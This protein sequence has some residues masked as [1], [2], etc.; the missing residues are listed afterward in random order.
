MV[1]I[2]SFGV[3]ADRVRVFTLGRVG[4]LLVGLFVHLP[5]WLKKLVC[6][7]VQ[8]PSWLKRLVYLKCSLTVLVK[9]VSVVLLWLVLDRLSRVELDF[10]RGLESL[11]S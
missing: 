7:R 6:L 1:E 8:L 4:L 5:S 2:R 3:I 9:E 10:C 11:L